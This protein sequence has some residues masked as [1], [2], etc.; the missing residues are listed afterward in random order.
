MQQL[1]DRFIVR[2]AQVFV[3]IYAAAHL[4]C[5]YAVLFP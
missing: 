2:L 3:V 1:L 5:A 4:G